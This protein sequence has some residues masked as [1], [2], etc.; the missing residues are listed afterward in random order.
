MKIRKVEI[1]EIIKN[2]EQEKL[3]E[4]ASADGGFKIKIA[5]YV[6]FCCTAVH[7]GSNLRQELH[8][9]IALNEY[10]RWYEEDP[11]TEDF[12]KSMPITIVG[13]DSRFEYD[14]NRNPNDCV[15]DEA[16]GKTVWKK[17]LT[18][19]EI[20]L[21]KQK[22]AAYFKVV[23]ALISKLEELFGG[24][25]VYDI[26]SYNYKR[27]DREV[28]LFNIGTEKIDLKLY[29]ETVQ[30][31]L[32]ELK[33][34]V[35]PDVSTS[36]V[37][38]DVFHG[39]GYNLEYINNHFRKTLVL[40]T[41]IKKVYCDELTGDPFPKIIR[42]LQQ[43]L[44]IAILN[45]TNTFCRKL[46]KWHHH[47]NNSLLDKKVNKNLLKIDHD[48][49]NLLKNIEVLA[50]VNP[51]NTGIEKNKFFK[52]KFSEIPNFKYNPIRINSFNLKQQLLSIPLQDI[53]DVSIRNLYKSVINSYF[54]KI[55]MIS[56]LNTDKFL[57]NSL[58]YFGRPSKKDLQNASYILLLPDIP[59]EAKKQP[60]FDAK[61]AMSRFKEELDDYGLE[62]KIELSNLVISQVMVLNSKRSILIHPQATFNRK[63]LLALLEHEIGIHMLTTINSTFQQLKIFNIGLPVNTL[64]QEGMAI[65]AEYLSGNLTLHR[66]K[67][68]AFRVIVVDQMCSGA[69]FIECFNLLKNE[70]SVEQNAAFNIVTRV[71]R[72]GGFTKDYL[73]L[74]GFVQV[75]RFWE[76][77]N[78]LIPLL[79]GKTSLQ[80]YNI[81]EEMIGREM[82]SPPKYITKS[83][84][85]PTTEQ[86]NSI[87][88][89]ILSGLK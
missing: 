38:N 78:D 28:P 47:S 61:T 85:K 37:T 26:H 53:Q 50:V 25:V 59:E 11:Y 64:T 24:C 2:I 19:Q 32:N 80:F 22:H 86:N 8:K 71:F 52:N 63:E 13:N 6:P 31:W 45:N 36:A 29:D 48:I 79:V 14:L 34:I 73:Y 88:N 84:L 12:I 72:G 17:K 30:N 58:R 65:L 56:S 87:Y 66:L 7:N 67:K 75:L 44:K 27:W 23:H 42:K 33:E 49:Y 62:A 5:R 16:W 15:Y 69:D 55:D 82:I 76:E 41:E 9:K 20:N 51:I 40:A 4:F 74:S 60:V 89:Y 43:S 1:G 70:Y 35:I 81:I 83:L 21:S 18:I 10:Q 3:F 77:Q 39:K 54:D 46:E 68:I 57:Y